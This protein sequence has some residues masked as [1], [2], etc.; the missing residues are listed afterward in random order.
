MEQRKDVVENI[1]NVSEV[2]PQ[3]RR[4]HDGQQ[5]RRHRCRR[6]SGRES[7]VLRPCG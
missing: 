2:I 6:E 1:K 3:G 7:A 4:G 5:A